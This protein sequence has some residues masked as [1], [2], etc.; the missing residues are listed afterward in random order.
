MGIWTKPDFNM[1]ACL[2]RNE[3]MDALY[4]RLE[5]EGK[6]VSGE[7]ITTSEKG[8]VEEVKEVIKETKEVVEET[9]EVVVEKG[10]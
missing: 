3:E 5:K 2:K 4:V 6:F 8:V 1:A 10:V 9:K 7:D